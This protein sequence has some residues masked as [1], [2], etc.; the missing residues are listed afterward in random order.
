MNERTGSLSPLNKRRA[1]KAAFALSLLAAL[2]TAVSMHMP[3]ALKEQEN[4]FKLSEVKAEAQRDDYFYWGR[5]LLSVNPAL[6]S[7]EVYEIGKAVV[8]Y[9]RAYRLSPK[10][11]VAVI[12]VESRGRLRAVSPRG[13][14]GLMQV[15]PWWPEVLGING[16]LYSID[17]NIRIGS[18]ILAENIRR[19]GH[20]EGILRYYRGGGIEDDGY[21]VKVQKAMEGLAG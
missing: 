13:A 11:I 4:S 10:L 14:I 12:K 6:K 7:H 21:F 19:W 2:T 1:L 17:I 9:S 16:D 18:H 20:K 5:H 3:K 8:R 15:M